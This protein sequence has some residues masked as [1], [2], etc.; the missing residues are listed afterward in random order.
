QSNT[1]PDPGAWESISTTSADSG[2]APAPASRASPAG[3]AWIT[4]GT[5][6]RT[7]RRSSAVSPPWSWAPLSPVRPTTSTTRSGVSL[8]NTPTVRI[9]G[10]SR[11]TMSRTTSG[12]TCR[13]LGAKTK[14]MASA[15][16]ATA[17]SASSSLV[18]PQTLTNKELLTGNGSDVDQLA[19]EEGVVGG[20]VEEAVAGVVEQDD[21]LLPRLLGRQRLVDRRPDG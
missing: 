21:A 12:W 5:R 7:S 3:S 9:S 13:G 18:T 19:V 16:M 15:P 14:P 11:F 17:S 4:N 6:S 2:P 8:R 1:S 10:G 20:Q